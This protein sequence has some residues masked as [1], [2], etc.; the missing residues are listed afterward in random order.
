M[1]LRAEELEFAGEHYSFEK[2]GTKG[3][4]AKRSSTETCEYETK[5]KGKPVKFTAHLRWQVTRAHSCFRKT[6]NEQSTP[7]PLGTRQTT[8]MVVQSC[9]PAIG[10]D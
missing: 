7:Q 8:P 9:S 1:K 5:E 6:R 4:I 3:M 10:V 2:L